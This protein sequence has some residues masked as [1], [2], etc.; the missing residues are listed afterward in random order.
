MAVINYFLNNVTQHDTLILNLGS[1]YHATCLVFK[2]I[3]GTNITKVIHVNTGFGFEATSMQQN[4]KTFYNL[5]G[6]TIFLTPELHIPFILFLKP[7]LFFRKINLSQQQNLEILYTVNVMSSYSEG[8]LNLDIN[9][10]VMKYMSVFYTKSFNNIY[11]Y[12]MYIYEILLND[13]K[14]TYIYLNEVFDYTKYYA[15]LQNVN[16]SLNNH[17]ASINNYNSIFN[18]NCQKFYNTWT[19]RKTMTIDSLRKHKKIAESNYL[20]KA[21]ENIDFHFDGILYITAQESG[22]CVFKS[23]LVSIM[24][25]I[26][27]YNS[28]SNQLLNYRCY[29]DYSYNFCFIELIK[30]IQTNGVMDDYL[31]SQFINTGKLF[32][33]L[34]KDNIISDIYYPNLLIQN[35]YQIISR[36]A[37]KPVYYSIVTSSAISKATMLVSCIPM[38]NIDNVLYNIRQQTNVSKH[39]L[40]QRLAIIIKK[41]LKN[42][43]YDDISRTYGELIL[44]GLIWE[45]YYNY[46]KWENKVNNEKYDYNNLIFLYILKETKSRIEFTTNEINW[47]CKLLYYFMY[48]YDEIKLTEILSLILDIDKLLSN[49]KTVMVN[50]SSNLISVNILLLFQNI[51]YYSL[52]TTAHYFNI[53]NKE[54]KTDILDI[55]QLGPTWAFFSKTHP[56]FTHINIYIDY[57]FSKNNFQKN[58][59][60]FQ[61]YLL[62][63]DISNINRFIIN[64]LKNETDFYIDI[65]KN[66]E[67][68]VDGPFYSNSY[69][70]YF[71]NMSHLKNMYLLIALINIYD[72]YSVYL[73][74]DEKYRVLKGLFINCKPI[75]KY[76]ISKFIN[77][78][79]I[80][81]LKHTNSILSDVYL[82]LEINKDLMKYNM[83][84]YEHTE[85]HESVLYD[86]N[87]SKKEKYILRDIGF[88]IYLYE[89]LLE[90]FENNGPI[91]KSIIDLILIKYKYKINSPYFKINTNDPTKIDLIIKDKTITDEFHEFT[92]ISCGNYNLNGLKIHFL[93][94]SFLL[95]DGNNK[96][97]INND[98]TYMVFVLKIDNYDNVEHIKPYMPHDVI[99]AFKTIPI[100]DS[101][102][103]I[104]NNAILLESEEIYINSNKAELDHYKLINKY[105]FMANASPISINIIEKT[106]DNIIVH[107]ISN[108]INNST[109][110]LYRII[111]NND[112]DNYYVN[113]QIKQNYLTPH[114]DINKI[115][116]L[117]FFYKNHEPYKKYITTR[118]NNSILIDYNKII[119]LNNLPGMD[120]L[121]KSKNAIKYID[122][123]LTATNNDV[124]GIIKAILDKQ[125]VKYIDLVTWINNNTNNSITAYD[126]D[127]KCNLNCSIISKDPFKNKIKQVKLIL[128]QLLNILLNKLNHD[129]PTYFEFIYHNYVYCSYIMQIN[130][131]ISLL[132]RL[133]RAIKTC[134][135]VLNNEL[136]GIEQTFTKKQLC[137]EYLEINQNFTER[138]KHISI[139]SG[140]VEIIFGHMIKNEQWEKILSMYDDYQNRGPT[141]KWNVHQFMM[142]KGKSSI[143]TPMLMTM[144][145]YNK[146][147]DIILCVP[148]HLKK[149][150]ENTLVE[151]KYYFGINPEILSDSDIKLKFLDEKDTIEGKV[152]LIDEFDYMYNPVQSNFN[153]I[154][155]SSS[156][157]LEVISKTFDI[158]HRVIY[159]KKPFTDY[160]PFGV[161]SEVMSV[162]NDSHNIK[163]VSFGM[164]VE[165]DYRYCIPYLRKDSP[166]EGSKFS[167][168]LYTV[169]LTILYFYNEKFNKYILEEKDII[170]AHTNTKLYNALL[171]I[172]KIDDDDLDH[173]L[174]KFRSIENKDAPDIP[175]YIMKM[176]LKVV[177]SYLTKSNI[178]K[179]CSFIDIINMDSEWQVGYSGTVNID[180]NF[181][182]INDNIKYN[183]AV[184]IDPD[185]KQQVKT[186]LT[187]HADILQINK[188]NIDDFFNIFVND[189]YNVLIDAC[190]LLK[191]YDNKE[192]AE[193]LFNKIRNKHN[194]NKQIIYLLKDD[195]KMIYNGKHIIYE[196]RNYKTEEVIYYYSQRHIIGIDFKQSTI[197]TGV[198][199]INS[200][201]IY[202]DVSQAIFRM[203]KLNKGH[204]IRIGYVNDN[205]SIS[206][207]A[208]IYALINENELNMNKDNNL[209][210]LYQYFKF[211]VRKFYT[212][213]YYEVNLRMFNEEPTKQTIFNKLKNNVFGFPLEGYAGN[214]I[215]YY[216]ENDYRTYLKMPNDPKI[217][218]LLGLLLGKPDLG[219]L[220]KLVFNTN[221]IQKEVAIETQTTTESQKAAYKETSIIVEINKTV[222]FRRL[223]IRYNPFLDINSFIN[224]FVYTTLNFNNGY[225]LLFSYNLVQN[226]SSYSSAILVQLDEHTFLLDNISMVNH[227]VYM[228]KIYN[229]KGINTNYFVFGKTKTKLDFSNMFN[230]T[231]FSRRDNK[232]INIA[233][234]IFG[235]DNE[236]VPVNNLFVDE[237][238]IHDLSI[239]FYL[240]NIYIFKIDDP[241]LKKVT[242]GMDLQLVN[243][244]RLVNISKK[245]IDRLY[246]YMEDYYKS[247]S[248][249]YKISSNEIIKRKTSSEIS[250]EIQKIIM[251]TFYDNIEF[252]LYKI[253]V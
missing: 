110:S 161:I 253:A 129:L 127:Y 159:L 242:D 208:E 94:G 178:V 224:N 116:Y 56:I 107:C 227:Y 79:L 237:T 160:K 96:G 41:Y 151:Y 233:Y 231:L 122:G 201:N 184:I 29:I 213:H 42:E 70:E 49:L 77:G 154:L 67:L 138:N 207:S 148:E 214:N 86:N 252:E 134:E 192:V 12:Y 121:S 180:F 241:I 188:D 106:D 190:A 240:S 162:L 212:K 142:G 211:Y 132:N 205:K 58:M 65:E 21:F 31:Y 197:L 83:G 47:I 37:R 193:I 156:L 235:I 118:F 248:N 157:D 54:T 194:I 46:D 130:I 221:T 25:F 44:I 217:D 170:L 218:E 8:V 164:S 32:S 219:E 15:K 206:S 57:L 123:I 239:L 84:S 104:V 251:Y 115:E 108:S 243:I 191:D 173:F 216:V 91:N 250:I 14:N 28:S 179:N 150:T 152:I 234:I 174:N 140:M 126:A 27:F 23:L 125:H 16:L 200:S 71:D 169:V 7:F 61:Q 24:Y 19:T 66:L 99:I 158:V 51:S 69:S 119:K 4:N 199:L 43:D 88:S 228:F 185:E 117:Q 226:I 113:F 62:D 90:I 59:N 195:T 236:E 34:I 249:N 198:V 181:K 144:I 95:N 89:K 223:A 55:K 102:G 165:K 146:P 81:V 53:Y 97:Y 80:K 9:A 229:L 60:I 75:L 98:Q 155:N 238:I 92:D 232:E 111:N 82:Y 100:T 244:H 171:R 120:I 78:I 103:N 222:Q 215:H 136:L 137:H 133:L 87:G 26:L 63:Y 209:L 183:Q 105:P 166:N 5:F 10:N 147:T 175:D 18:N 112:D 163:N 203:R 149:Q 220:L 40:Q 76:P 1:I 48:K 177:C 50:N 30:T 11:E 196:E 33:Q 2:K 131:Y 167:S 109:N 168:I 3:P 52:Q 182:S 22:T 172:Y 85:N 73:T 124:S 13:T 72:L 17:I 35:N 64:Y 225:K 230:Y 38:H 6:K 20:V 74:N 247:V 176:Y 246:K 114:I 186:A 68:D 143:I 145:Y 245:F 204:S 101:N 45:L 139:L 141:H 189:N 39:V 93:L 135:P 187:Y 36:H 128:Q 210:L 202:T 153:K